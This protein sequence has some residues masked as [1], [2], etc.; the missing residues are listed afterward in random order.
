[1]PNYKIQPG[2]SGRSLALLGPWEPEFRIS[3]L[4][5]GIRELECNS[6][7]GWRGNNIDFV[8]ELPWL[9]G[10]SLTS[11]KIS[12]FSPLH[13]LNSLVYLSIAGHG[14]GLID[15]SSFPKLECCF[16]E[17]WPGVKSVLKC[18]TLK[19]A[20]FNSCKVKHSEQLVQ[21]GNLERFVLANGPINEVQHLGNFSKLD[22]LGLYLLRKVDCLKGLE[23]LSSLE[24]LHI[25]G[26]RRITNLEPLSGLPSLEVLIIDDNG[27]IDSLAPLLQVPTLKQLYFT[28]TTFIKDGDMSVIERLPKLRHVAFANR[29]HY[30][31]R[32][33]DFPQFES[34]KPKIVRYPL[35]DWTEEELKV[36]YDQ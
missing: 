25:E 2:V 9:E 7:K 11:Y 29:A 15:F 22:Y 27:V 12:D 14:K 5:L 26:C 20:Y 19:R 17:W 18:S 32:C 1:M 16:L 33:E 31:H 10:F 24:W 3:M 8:R 28:G 21:L 35:R 13:N 6:A 4:S 23:R 36:L 34:D 30:S